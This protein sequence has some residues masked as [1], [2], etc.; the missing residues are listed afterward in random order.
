[1]VTAF[2]GLGAS[3]LLATVGQTLLR[4]DVLA[5]LGRGLTGLG[6]A[7]TLLAAASAVVLVLW[8]LV[9]WISAG[10]GDDA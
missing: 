1:M 5:L 4:L 3:I 10:L 7:G 6:V 2:G 8:A 9:R